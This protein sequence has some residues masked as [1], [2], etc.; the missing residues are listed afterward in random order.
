MGIRAFSWVGV[1]TYSYRIV[2]NVPWPA[3]FESVKSV[4]ATEVK[5]AVLN[6]T[7]TRYIDFY[8]VGSF[9]VLS[10][11]Y[12]NYRI[13]NIEIAPTSLDAVNIPCPGICGLRYGYIVNFDI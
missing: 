10:S 13:A 3:S 1:V 6:V 8:A 12:I 4:N 7:M 5:G 9:V 11:C 2:M